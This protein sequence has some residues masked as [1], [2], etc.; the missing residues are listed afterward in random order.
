MSQLSKPR[1]SRPG[2]PSLIAEASADCGVPVYRGV[3]VSPGVADAPAPG[4]FPGVAVAAPVAVFLEAAAAEALLSVVRASGLPAVFSLHRHSVAPCSDDFVPAAEP[5]VVPGPAWRRSFPDFARASDPAWR[6]RCLMELGGR[7]EERHWDG[8]YCGGE[9]YC[10]LDAAHCSRDG[11]RLAG[12]PAARVRDGWGRD[13]RALRP[14][15]LAP[16]RGL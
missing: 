14:S 8:L 1:T 12:W 13:Y 5:A 16:L 3:V 4:V 10:S 15:W 11:Q 7:L 2:L 9:R 6:H